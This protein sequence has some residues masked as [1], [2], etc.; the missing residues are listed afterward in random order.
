M[1][2]PVK[3]G[4]FEECFDAV[5]M[6]TSD[7]KTLEERVGQSSDVP[8][9]FV[10]SLYVKQSTLAPNGQLG[11]FLKRDHGHPLPLDLPIR[12]IACLSG[13]VSNA[14]FC[15]RKLVYTGYC[16]KT[17]QSEAT[18]STVGV[19]ARERSGRSQQSNM[20]V[21]ED[22][23]LD[24]RRRVLLEVRGFA[25]MISNGSKRKSGEH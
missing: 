9:R 23:I 16:L 19:R 21:A 22:V 20:T 18:L 25:G 11:V 14:S 8:A 15:K 12:G 1:T 3:K 5:A 7:F 17:S 13:D 24:S 10:D 2:H 6:T 4:A